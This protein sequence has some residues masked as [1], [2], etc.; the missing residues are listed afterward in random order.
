MKYI[1]KT[2]YFGNSIRKVD[3]NTK[4]Y[5]PIYNHFFGRMYIVDAMGGRFVKRHHTLAIN[6]D[7]FTLKLDVENLTS[8]FTRRRESCD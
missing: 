6:I 8:A 7:W 4:I 2:S 5:I 3:Y 1:S